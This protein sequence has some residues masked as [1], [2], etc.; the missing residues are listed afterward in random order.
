[1][2]GLP[3]FLLMAL[4]APGTAAG[5]VVSVHAPREGETVFGQVE[6]E[7]E[8]LSGEKVASVE[9]RLDGEVVARLTA[10]PYRVVVDVGQTNQAHVFEVTAIDVVGGRDTRR[11]LTGTIAVDEQV[12]IELQQLYVTVT[13][14]GKRVLDLDARRF[15]VLDNG[16]RQEMVTFERGDVPLTA[17]LLIDSS[18]SMEGEALAAAL[19]G[20]LAFVEGMGTLDEAKVMVFS[21]RL[22]ATTPFTGDPRIV[23]AALDAV[24]P[25]GSTAINDHLFVGLKELEARQGRKV[26]VLLSDGL[27]VDSVLGMADVEWKV[28]RVPT[29]LYWIRLLS[30]ADL[31]KPHSSVW[32]DAT[33]QRGEGEALERVMTAS[34]GRVF[35]IDRIEEAAGAFREI[36]REL[37]EQ[38]VLGYYPSSDLDDGAWH[39]VEVRVASPG[40]KVRARGGYYDERF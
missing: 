30:G 38:Y 7:I 16:Q 25:T 10:P 40:V 1:M 9:V 27:D 13:R 28:G 39:Q 31:D 37:R 34:G 11:V 15:D 12:E 26:V 35:S 36:L 2:R 14:D 3:A 33:E 17:V 20:A 6:V 22:L 21:D 18:L 19:A 24:T 4:L 29:V 23:S 32:R 5:I 8:V